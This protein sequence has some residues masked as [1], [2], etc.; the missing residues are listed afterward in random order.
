MRYVGIASC[1]GLAC[2]FVCTKEIRCPVFSFQ[3]ATHAAVYKPALEEE[4]NGLKKETKKVM[5]IV[6]LVVGREA[7]HDVEFL[8]KQEVWVFGK[9]SSMKMRKRNQPP[10]WPHSC[11]TSPSPIHPKR[12]F[13]RLSA[14][15]PYLGAL[16]SY[17]YSVS[18]G[19]RAR[20][21]SRTLIRERQ[22][23]A[24][25]YRLDIHR[26]DAAVRGT[27]C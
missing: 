6:R 23:S 18:C 26:W 5:I 24:L 9:P 8:I 15:G 20:C 3:P 14:A 10:S 12:E 4:K 27:S 1:G 19:R 22:G 7:H 11:L 2:S 25:R 17:R 16:S 13:Q 21:N